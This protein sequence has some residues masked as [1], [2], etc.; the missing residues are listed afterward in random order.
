M[1]HFIW[2]F[3]LGPLSGL[4]VKEIFML[5]LVFRYLF[6]MIEFL[7]TQKKILEEIEKGIR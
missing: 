6:Y 1:I 4:T 3:L 5:L 7:E 2:N